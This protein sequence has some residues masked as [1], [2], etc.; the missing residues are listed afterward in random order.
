MLLPYSDAKKIIDG[1]KAVLLNAFAE[2]GRCASKKLIYDL[3]A[4]R[5]YCVDN[6]SALSSAIAITI[7]HGNQIDG[8]VVKAIESL[9]VCR[10]FHLRHT[11]KY[12]LLIDEDYRNAYAVKALTDPLHDIAGGKS[13]TFEAG[14]FE[15]KKH[16]VC[17]GIIADT[18]HLG[19]NIRSELRET[20]NKI[21][22][23]GR[24]YATTVA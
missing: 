8:E 11:T 1:Y 9:K 2:S 4:A 21:K 23:A 20:Y 24:F 18:V 15:Y 16:Y 10:W 13:F 5:S 14:V 17:D 19:P 12:A 7:A 22:E 3:A 6:P